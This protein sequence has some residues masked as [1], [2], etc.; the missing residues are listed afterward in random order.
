MIDFLL[1]LALFTGGFVL[2]YILGL[3]I[4]ELEGSA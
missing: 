2:G 4:L 3:I 1:H